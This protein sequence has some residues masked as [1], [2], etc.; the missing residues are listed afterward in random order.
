MSKWPTIRPDRAKKPKTLSS[1]ARPAARPDAQGPNSLRPPLQE[2]VAAEA[3]GRPH[4]RSPPRQPII[5]QKSHIPS[6]NRN[7]CCPKR[8]LVKTAALHATRTPRRRIVRFQHMRA[9]PTQ[10][11]PIKKSNQHR[12]W[13]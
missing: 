5:R 10:L 12:P 8:L 9:E 3:Y 6:D 13:R 4:S 2:K 7:V 1:P 11:R